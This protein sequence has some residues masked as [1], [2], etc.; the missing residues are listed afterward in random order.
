MANETIDYRD[1]LQKPLANFPDRPNLE[2]GKILYGKLVSITAGASKQKGTPLF[3][4]DVRFTD[5]GADYPKASLDKLSAA[6]FSLA[7]YTCGADFYLVPGAMVF[8]R[9]FLV[10]LGF[11]ENVTFR[12][13]LKL[14]DTGEPTMD[15]QEV[16]RGMDVIIRTPPADDQ[17]RV[18][19]NNVASEGMIAGTKR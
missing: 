15:S 19:L 10:S 2:P 17:G 16:I 9:R 13:A 6:G 5:P 1:L 14:T 11:S 8:L 18:F 3:H 12:E 7:D 4:F